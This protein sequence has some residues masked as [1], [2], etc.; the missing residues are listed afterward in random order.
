MP[1]DTHAAAA[2]RPEPLSMELLLS[3]VYYLM[4]RYA[5]R[6]APCVARAIIE[7]LQLIAGHPECQS[8]LV[9]NAGRRLALQWREHI[10]V[11]HV[12]PPGG[13]GTPPGRRPVKL[14]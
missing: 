4:T 9:R 7:H 2:Q 13:T 5:R 11:Q 6:P 8:E 1:D 14:H 12:A 10:L 3:S